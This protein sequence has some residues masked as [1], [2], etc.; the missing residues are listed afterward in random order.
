MD[1]PAGISKSRALQIQ[2]TDGLQIAGMKDAPMWA[3]R[4]T[5]DYDERKIFNSLL[6]EKR[7]IWARLRRGYIR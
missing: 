5:I 7:R 1:I 2:L 3:V 4:R 6:S